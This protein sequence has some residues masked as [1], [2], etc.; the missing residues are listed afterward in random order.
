MEHTI[1]DPHSHAMN[2]TT[3]KIARLPRHLRD[4]LNLQLQEAE[5][6][7]RVLEWLNGKPEVKAL[8]TDGARALT[9]ADLAQWQA[10]GYPE[11]L[12]QQEALAASRRMAEEV[13]EFTNL[14]TEPLTER[15]AAWLAVRYVAESRRLRES[16]G[17]PEQDWQRLRDFSSDVAALRRGDQNA[18]RL[19]I[20]RE[21][22]V[23]EY[24]WLM[25]AKD[26]SHLRWKRKFTM[27]MEAFQELVNHKNEKAKAAF[28]AFAAAVSSPFD[29]L[30]SDQTEEARP[31][32]PG[33]PR[34]AKVVP[35]QSD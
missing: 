30:E 3:G 32:P 19:R 1:P 12:A 33:A 35:T 17:D 14:E 7:Q 10:G 26:D 11:W 31:N 18:E 21:R 28:K 4:A 34:P 5:L 16:T 6:P 15:L 20:E 23:L 29:S 24:K 9:A 13:G 8:R 22:L 2:T 27:A 25:Q